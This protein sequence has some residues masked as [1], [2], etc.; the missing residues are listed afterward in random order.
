MWIWLSHTINQNTEGYRGEKSLIINQT[1]SIAQGN[2]S[3]SITFSMHNHLGTHVDAPYHFLNDGATIS[4]YNAS[5]WVFN[6]P[7]I[8]NKALEPGALLTPELVE[9]DIKTNDNTDIILIKT[10]FEKYRGTEI[11]WE[12][13]PGYSSD[14]CGLF[15][16]KYKSLKAIG[17][18]SISLSS[19]KHRDEGKKAHIKFL[20]NNI[21]I[22]EDLKLSSIQSPLIKTIVALPLSIDDLDGGPCSI[23]ANIS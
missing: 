2:S 19:L 3:N 14:L 1:S 9:N 10:G 16:S 22:F 17:I 15:I 11:Y 7:K 20:S 13:T 23:V 12:N 6:F 4:D 5:D 8:I 18:D 21:R